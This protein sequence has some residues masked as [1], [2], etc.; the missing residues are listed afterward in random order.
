MISRSKALAVMP[1]AIASVFSLVVA[2]YFLCFAASV[3]G[4]RS[5]HI[6][7]LL[8]T[9]AILAFAHTKAV[10]RYDGNRFM[11]TY[12]NLLLPAC[13]IAIILFLVAEYFLRGTPFQVPLLGVTLASGSLTV[14]VLCYR[15]A[16]CAAFGSGPGS[17]SA[18]S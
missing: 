9:F 17:G 15:G 1:H 6:V 13:L 18:T 12:R 2:A 16:R 10:H 7:G 14:S 11:M 5:F 3:F 8:S 4:W